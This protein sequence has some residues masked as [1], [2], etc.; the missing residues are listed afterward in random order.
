MAIV[1]AE[2]N[3]LPLV[4]EII[5]L[6]VE[7]PDKT[8]VP[9]WARGIGAF[10][11]SIIMAMVVFAAILLLLGKNPVEVYTSMFKGTLATSYGISEIVVKMI[12]FI[13]CAL[14]VAI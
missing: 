11:L 4:A 1:N 5:V 13:L 3:S 6:P 12:P 7:L 10:L 2:D 14:A 9:K 8:G